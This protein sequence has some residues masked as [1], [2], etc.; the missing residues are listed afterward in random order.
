MPQSILIWFCRVPIECSEFLWVMWS[1]FFDRTLLSLFS[2]KSG[3][4]LVKADRRITHLHAKL[5]KEGGKTI[6]ILRKSVPYASQT[7]C[8]IGRGRGGQFRPRPPSLA[9]YAFVLRHRVSGGQ[10]SG[11]AGANQQLKHRDQGY[12]VRDQGL[13]DAAMPFPCFLREGE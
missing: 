12:C 4:N 5:R 2:T 3:C 9:D 7:G 6:M 11:R 8:R 13:Q 1:D 10:M